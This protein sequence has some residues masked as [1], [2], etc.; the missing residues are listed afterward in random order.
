MRAYRC[1]ECGERF[2]NSDPANP[3]VICQNCE[4]TY[5]PH[6]QAVKDAEIVRAANKTVKSDKPQSVDPRAGLAVEP[7]K[8]TK[9]KN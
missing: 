5:T 9:G 2:Y 7:S 6:E 3:S 1:K 8:S 4:G